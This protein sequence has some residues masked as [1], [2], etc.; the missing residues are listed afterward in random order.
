LETKG[1]TW[2]RIDV[3]LCP[4]AG[5]KDKFA[6]QTVHRLHTTRAPRVL[7][8]SFST[9]SDSLPIL[10]RSGSAFQPT[11]CQPLLLISALSLRCSVS[12]KRPFFSA[13][14]PPSHVFPS[15]PRFLRTAPSFPCDGRS[16]SLRYASTSPGL[17]SAARLYQRHARFRHNSAAAGLRSKNRCDRAVASRRKRYSRSRRGIDLPICSQ[18]ALE[19]GRR[20][21]SALS[22]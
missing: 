16:V 14:P 13:S 2:Q 6:S 20:N 12:L 1:P 21:A 17:R 3:S 4:A 5:L 18:D 15:N 22:A 19:S 7:A 8:H 9:H 10:L 11:S